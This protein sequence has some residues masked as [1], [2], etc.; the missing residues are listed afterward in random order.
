MTLRYAP[1]SIGS[2]GSPTVVVGGSWCCFVVADTVD[3]MWVTC[4]CGRRHYGLHGAA[5]LVLIDGAGQLLMTH[6]SEH[7]HFPGTWSFPGGA[8]EQGETPADA[9]LRELL[10][11]VGVPSEAVTVVSVVPGLDH[12]LWRYTYVFGLLKPAWSEVPLTSNWEIEAVKWVS[13]GDLETLPLHPDLRT[14]LPA[15]RK[16]LAL[17]SQAG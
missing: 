8:L 11:E 7:V 9:A 13:P 4:R 14:D 10:E 3:A 16:A 1:A 12:E 15:L 2:A 6:R 5:G 17:V